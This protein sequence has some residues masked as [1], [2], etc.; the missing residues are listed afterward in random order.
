MVQ[1]LGDRPKALPPT[2]KEAR[3]YEREYS[4]AGTVGL[5][6]N[7]GKGGRKFFDFRYNYNHKKKFLR[8]GEWPGMSLS[9]ARNRAREYRNLLYRGIDPAAER[10]R[11]RLAVTFGEFVDKEYLPFAKAT[12]KSVRDDLS[13]LNSVILPAWR[14]L[15]LSAITTRDRSISLCARQGQSVTSHNESLLRAHPPNL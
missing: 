10:N 14:T 5:R 4:D 8:L 11:R 15:P 7:V 9:D 12:K 1:F 2:P 13:K 6:L 3:Q